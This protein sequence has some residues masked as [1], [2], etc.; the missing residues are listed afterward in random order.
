MNTNID[1]TTQLGSVLNRAHVRSWNSFGARVNHYNQF[2][3]QSKPVIMKID[4]KYSTPK[5]AAMWRNW[6]ILHIFRHRI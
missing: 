4:V 3:L 1:P 2:A 5:K 6:R